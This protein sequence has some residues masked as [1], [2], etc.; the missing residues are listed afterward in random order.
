MDTAQTLLLIVVVVLTSL[1][2][3]LG[4]QVYFILRELRRTVTKANKVLDAAGVIT[5]SVSGPIA[6]LSSL[7]TG[8]KTGAFIASLLNKHKKQKEKNEDGESQ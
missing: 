1:L 4:I 6:S 3:L 5:E 7:V 8:F 2:L